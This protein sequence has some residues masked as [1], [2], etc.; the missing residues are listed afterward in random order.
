MENKDV[1]DT[2]VKSDDELKDIN[3]EALEMLSNN[4]GD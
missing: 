4:K 1:K 3:K 2:E